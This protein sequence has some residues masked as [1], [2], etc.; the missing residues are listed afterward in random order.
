MS[1]TLTLTLT[2]RQVLSGVPNPNPNPNLAPGVERCPL[3]PTSILLTLRQV[4]RG[5]C[6]MR[7]LLAYRSAPGQEV[8][9]EV[10]MG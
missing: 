2:L 10:G 3:P 1:L 6:M 4:L 9:Q 8:G 7:R 5:V